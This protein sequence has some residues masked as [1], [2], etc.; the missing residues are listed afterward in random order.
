[1]SAVDTVKANLD[2]MSPGV[3]ESAEQ[4]A[5]RLL[6]WQNEIYSSHAGRDLGMEWEELSEEDKAS[7][8]KTA[9]EKGALA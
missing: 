6:A 5:R 2:G 3:G 4:F 9:Q 1:M 7:W 8:I